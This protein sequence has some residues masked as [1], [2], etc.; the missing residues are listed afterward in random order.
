MMMP[1][2]LTLALMR[3]IVAL[4]SWP[5]MPYPSGYFYG[6]LPG[7]VSHALPFC[8]PSLAV[9][10]RVADLVSRLS[11]EEKL[12]LLGPDTTDTGVGSCSDMDAGVARLGI[13]RITHLVEVNTAAGSECLGVGKCATNFPGPTGLAGS[14]NRSLWRAKGDVIASEMRAL[15]NI[16]GSR[17]YEAPNSKIG[18]AGFGPNINI[19]RDPRFGR[20]SEV[21]GEDPFLS[22]SY[23]AEMVKGMQAANQSKF[24]KMVAGLK[25]YTAYSTETDRSQAFFNISKHDLWDTYLPAYQMGFVDG[26]AMATMCSYAG[27]T[28]PGKTNAPSCASE[29]LLKS[30]IREQ[31]QRP[32]V[33]VQSDCG[34]ITNMVGDDFPGAGGHYAKNMTDATA[35]A[36]NAGCDADDGNGVYSPKKFGGQ[37]LLEA[38]IKAGMVDVKTVDAAVSRVLSA[39]RFRVG[40]A[41]PLAGQA[42]RHY[43]AHTI[44]STAHQALNL[45]ASLQAQVLLRND[46]VLPF[47]ASKSIAVVGPLTAPGMLISDYPND[48]LCFGGPIRGGDCWPSLGRGM[49]MVA[50][51]G[52]SVVTAPGCDKRILANSGEA[53]TCINLKKAANPAWKAAVAA[54]AKAEQ[55][56]LALGC[57]THS[58]GH[59]GQD[60]SDTLLPGEQQEFALEVLAL[61]KP[62]VIVLVNGGVISVDPLLAKLQASAKIAIVE[63]FYPSIR[64]A[65]ALA[66]QLLGKANRWGKLSVTIYDFKYVAG[67]ALDEFS[68]APSA[69]CPLGRTYRY[70]KAKPLYAFGTGISLTTFAFACTSITANVG[71]GPTS[72]ACT[73]HNTGTLAGD[74]VLMVYHR[75]AP[76]AVAKLAYPVP[77]RALVDFERVTVAAGGQASVEFTLPRAKLGV[78]DGGGDRVVLAG[79]HYF[80]VSNGVGVQTVEVKVSAASVV[81][82]VP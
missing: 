81:D 79:A 37:G 62:T 51:G 4:A 41:D 45:E 65:E 52:A 9:A 32:D 31:W 21:P 60:R 39:T 15:N 75:L 64:G 2:A 18:L 11:L 5:I 30:V 6:C 38:A 71:D 54:A 34:A 82:R 14:F 19:A 25:H 50:G 42:Y 49:G 78:V 47:T 20:T 12:G 72:I 67:C 16:G 59:E 26:G 44:N 70:T 76:A 28:T 66:M 58:C 80:D 24:F 55:V 22:G 73:V 53:D 33:V 48:Q 56:V 8:D 10:Q 74:E 13:P 43:G 29:Y 3:P 17:G 27:V 61:G 35:K 36:M 40:L 69:R 23:A 7:N 57:D 1:V 68:M 63:A 77:S 46:G